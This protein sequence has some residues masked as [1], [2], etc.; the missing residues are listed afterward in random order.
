MTVSMSTNDENLGY[1]WWIKVRNAPP[2]SN[3]IPLEAAL[4]YPVCAQG[5]LRFFHYAVN[6]DQIVRPFTYLRATFPDMEVVEL[7]IDRHGK[8]FP[9]LPAEPG[10]YGVTFDRE[11]RI[12]LLNLI[13]SLAQKYLREPAGE[14]G[15]TFLRLFNQSVPETLK[16][17]YEAL[18]PQF[19]QWLSS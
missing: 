7:I 9:G 16:P 10:V 18:N 8:L 11:R 2:V 15:Q 1:R 5:E 3:Q 19:F 12:A 6:N 14:T 4:S 13:P 17:F